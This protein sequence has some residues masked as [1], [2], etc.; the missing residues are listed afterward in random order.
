MI[1]FNNDHTLLIDVQYVNGNKKEKQPDMLYVIWKDTRKNEKH[2]EII[3]EPKMTIYFEKEEFRNHDYNLNYQEKNKMVPLTCKYKDIKFAIANEM[4]EPGKRFLENV[5]STK[6]YGDLRELNRYPFVFGHDFDIRT[7][8]RYHWSK[9]CP[10]PK[11]KK[12]SIGFLD[13]ETDS[14][15][16]EGFTD[17]ATCPVDLVTIIDSEHM[18]SYTL[19]LTGQIYE[20]KDF[21]HIP[22][23]DPNKKRL[24]E[25]E[26]ERKKWHDYRNQQEDELID[27]LDKLKGEL[28]EMFDETYGELEYNF[29]FYKS[30]KKLLIHLFQLINQLKL[31]F[32]LI[33]NMSFDIPYLIDRM[34]I[35]GLDPKEIMCHPD[36]P[37]KECRFNKDTRNFEVKNKSDNFQL[38]S[39][40]IFYDQMILY[41]AIR[42][43]QEELRSHKLNYIGEREVGDKKLDYSEEGNIK[44]LPYVNYWKY[45]IY[46]IKDVLL[47][48][49]I[50]RATDDIST[51]YVTSYENL[52]SYKDVFKQTVV[53]RN[54]QY[55]SFLSK[56]LVPGANINQLDIFSNK[57][58]NT[59]DDG[60]KEDDDDGVNFE[61]ALVGNP[62]LINNFGSEIYGKKTNYLFDFSIDMDMSAFY[63]NTIHVL[64]IDASTLIFKAIVDPRQYDVRGGKIPFKGITDVQL[65]KENDDSFKDDIGGEIFDNFHSKN[66]L[67]L[68]YKFLN[69]PSAEEMQKILENEVDKG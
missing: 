8:Y 42:K 54:V 66:Y 12:F 35:N 24:I 2:L 52:T 27:N 55:K 47:Q 6:R 45:V 26:H 23:S 38:S 4:G 29:Y 20:E 11:E 28:H 40:T 5:F 16:I 50:E 7:Y 22:D 9:S 61:G 59:F 30:E 44:K 10:E 3:P 36:F 57:N 14:F 33:W 18:K 13:I 56:G 46:N 67:S 69:L 31:D 1:D 37:V 68:G 39:Y 15:D 51:L 25:E 41:A 58:K 17:S 60:E 64:N 63:P 19:A 48:M 34:M 65:V 49:G 62:L 32:M 43:G 21:S 53:L